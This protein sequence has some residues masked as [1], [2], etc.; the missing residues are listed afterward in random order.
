MPEAILPKQGLE[1]I[2]LKGYTVIYAKFGRFGETEAKELHNKIPH[3]IIIYE[4]QWRNG[5][6]EGVILPENFNPGRVRFYKSAEQEEADAEKKREEEVEVLRERVMATIPGVSIRAYFDDD[7]VV[8]VTL[9]QEV[10][11]D[12]SVR[13]KS[14]Q[15]AQEGV[16]RM[17]PIWEE[18]NTRGLEAFLRHSGKGN[19][20]N[21]NIELI[22]SPLGSKRV[23]V[24][25]DFGKQ[26]YAVFE[27]QEDGSWK[28]T[29]TVRGAPK[30]R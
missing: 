10:F 25:Y 6:G 4:F 5:F 2:D 19:P 28:E 13:A 14:L 22:P 29:G 27:Q 26:M 16:D 12:W 18:W 21:G 1:G 23:G 17:R 8:L 9:E 24:C 3:A 20:G 11:S 30:Y 15:E 7:S